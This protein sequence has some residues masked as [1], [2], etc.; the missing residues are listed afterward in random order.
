MRSELSGDKDFV[1]IS[2]A[3]AG[4]LQKRHKA[5]QDRSFCKLYLTHVSLCD[6]ERIRAVYAFR[7]PERSLSVLIDSYIFRP[8]VIRVELI[9]LDERAGLSYDTRPQEFLCDR[10]YSASAD[11]CRFAVPYHLDIDPVFIYVYVLDSAFGSAHSR[12]DI[13]SLKSRSCSA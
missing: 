7:H 13:H 6:I 5:R 11:T 1:K 2:H 9:R 8:V 4:L 12:A 3:Y 10:E